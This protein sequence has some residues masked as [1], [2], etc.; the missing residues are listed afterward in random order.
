[1]PSILFFIKFGTTCIGQAQILIN[2]ACSRDIG[3]MTLL[4]EE[5]PLEYLR[6]KKLVG[7]K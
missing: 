6:S 4:F 3:L 1:M 2:I 5:L 7:R